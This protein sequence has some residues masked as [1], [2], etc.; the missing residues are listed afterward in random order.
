MSQVPRIQ[1]SVVSELLPEDLQRLLDEVNHLRRI[2]DKIACNCNESNC[3][4]RPQPQAMHRWNS[5][6]SLPTSVDSCDCEYVS[7]DDAG[8]YESFRPRRFIRTRP[9][10]KGSATPRRSSLVP[11]TTATTGLTHRLIVPHSS[12]HRGLSAPALSSAAS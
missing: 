2:A 3:P 1:V 5:T 4:F 11:A 7:D 8:S 9:V 10:R 12:I 6:Q